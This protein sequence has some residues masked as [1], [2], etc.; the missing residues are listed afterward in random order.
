MVTAN[1]S[2]QSRWVVC[3]T[4]TLTGKENPPLYSLH[5]IRV[6]LRN[7]F[8]EVITVELM[9]SGDRPRLSLLGRPE[10]GVTFTKIHCWTLTQFTKCVF[11]DA[12]TLV[13]ASE[14]K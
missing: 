3:L 4:C 5:L 13:S 2:E 10:L 9:D 12:D 8:D 14:V 11:L 7:V 1:V 6:S